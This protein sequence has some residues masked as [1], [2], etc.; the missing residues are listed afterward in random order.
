MIDMWLLNCNDI[1]AL[2][3][4]E[5][6]VYALERL[7][8]VLVVHSQGLVPGFLLVVGVVRHL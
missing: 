3:M 2:S 8:R 4:V 6:V 1:V 7:I 5:H